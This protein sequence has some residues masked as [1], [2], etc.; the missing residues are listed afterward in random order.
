MAAT[1]VQAFPGD[2]VIPGK[3]YAIELE[4]DL[5]EADKSATTWY[6]LLKGG[7]RQGSDGYSTKC[8]LLVLAQGLHECVTFDFNYMI[9]LGNAGGCGLN[10]YRHDSFFSR[11]GIVKFRL[12]EYANYVFY[13][14]MKIDH[15]VV[16]VDRTWTV[17]LKVVQGGSAVEA[18]TTFLE[19]ITTTTGI[20]TQK[21]FDIGLSAFA[22]MPTSNAAPFT[23]MSTGNVG[24][25]K[26]N[27]VYP[28]DVNGTFSYS[29]TTYNHGI[30]GGDA[31]P[32]KDQLINSG[33]LSAGNWYR[34]AKNGTAVQGGTG[35]N[36]CMARFT[37]TDVEGSE[38]ST[39][40]F[41]AG[42]TFGRDPFFH[43]VANTSH[44]LPGVIEKVR[45][46]DSEDA[47]AEGC[48]IDIYIHATVGSN[49]VQ[50]VMDDNI[51]LSGFALANYEANPNITG[52]LVAEYDLGDITWG[53]S[54]ADNGADSGIFMAQTGRV[55]IGTQTPAVPLHVFGDAAES[56]APFRIQSADQFAGMIMLDNSGGVQIGS[57]QGTLRFLTDYAA[58]LTGGHEVARLTENELKIKATRNSRIFIEDTGTDNG[59]YYQG[60]YIGSPQSNSDRG[61]R[62]VVTHDS[63]HG[64]NR[65]NLLGFTGNDMK[66]SNFSDNS[67]TGGAGTTLMT[68]LSG[69]N[70]GIG[71]TTPGSKLTVVG[72]VGT[73][74][75]ISV[76]KGAT[77]S[78]VMRLGVSNGG[79]G[80]NFYVGGGGGHPNWAS[81]GIPL[82]V[83]N[84]GGGTILFISNLNYTGG[85]GTQSHFNMIRQRYDGG[86]DTQNIKN[87][88]GGGV[89]FQNSSNYLQYKFTTTGNG[90][91]YAIHC[92]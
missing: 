45:I 53:V 16:D 42:S 14:D 5:A 17:N 67:A 12:T 86:T 1:N 52:M 32:V 29:G 18:P 87:I 54:P 39:R 64:S 4:A 44:D 60:V 83:N 82:T 71:S 79:T 57:D 65:H 34:I 49:A 24:I 7:L 8:E 28:L 36:R 21:E 78:K 50:V 31:H 23:I 38:H 3:Q 68:V 22:V 76:S 40:I 58:D 37:L 75:Q 10:V 9:Q 73:T 6:R 43:L 80:I 89:Q 48:A 25:G 19:K 51:Q 91:F 55:G 56:S 35:G 72:T 15:D 26:S 85:N 41:Y 77:Y 90:H 59:T 84:S 92:D 47:D 20:A 66:I 74:D 11:V 2:V 30:L 62:M 61:M 27:P 13:L 33:T 46:V 70:V 69:G 63:N 81:T 88:N